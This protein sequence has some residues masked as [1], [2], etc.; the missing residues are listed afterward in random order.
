MQ[1]AQNMK[2]VRLPQAG[3]SMRTSKSNFQ[4]KEVDGSTKNAFYLSDS[5]ESDFL[6]TRH[7]SGSWTSTRPWIVER[8][9]TIYPTLP[10]QKIMQKTREKH[11]ET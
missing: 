5:H 3:V 11:D 10:H 1:Y 8:S 9:E 7:I 6:K 4:S 2:T